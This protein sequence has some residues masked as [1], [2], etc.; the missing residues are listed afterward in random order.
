MGR[1][2]WKRISFGDPMCTSCGTAPMKADAPARIVIVSGNEAGRSR[3]ARLL[4]EAGYIAV[5]AGGEAAAWKLIATNPSS[6]GLVILD[7]EL[8]NQSGLALCRRIKAEYPDIPVLLTSAAK[9]SPKARG[10]GFKAGADAYL[11]EPAENVEILAHIRALYRLRNADEARRQGEKPLRETE[12][13]LSAPAGAA[14]G[15]VN[16][17]AG[18]AEDVTGRKQAEERWRESEE[19][20][21]VT[22]ET[23]AVGMTHAAPDGRWLRVN[24]AFSDIV[25]YSRQELLAG[26]TFADITH[27]DD[28]DADWR[29]F[30]EVLAGSRDSY[31]LEKRYIHK[32]GHFVHALIAVSAV[33]KADGAPDYLISAVQDISERKCAEAALRESEEKY[34][35][36]FESIDEGFCVIDIILDAAGRPV[37]YRFLEV[38]AVFEHQTGLLNAAGKTALELVPDLERWWIDTYGRVALTGESARFEHGSVPMGRIFDVYAS[39]VGGDTSRKVALVFKDITE[40][41]RIEERLRDSEAKFRTITNLIPGIVWTA[42]AVGAA[43]YASKQWYEF[44]GSAPDAPVGKMFLEVVHPD[45][46]QRSIAGWAKAQREGTVYQTE[47]RL[48]SRTGDYRWFFTRGTPIRDETGAIVQWFGVSIDVHD[49]RQT[50]EALRLSERQYRA[51]FDNAAIGIAHVGL[52]GRFLR[53]NARLCEKL[54]FGREELLTKTWMDLSHPDEI[55]YN[56]ELRQ[57]ALRGETQTY[58]LEKRLFRKDGAVIWAYL[59]AGLLRDDYGNPL[60]FIAFIQN[61]TAR[62]EA[63]ERLR[64]SEERFRTVAAVIP[65]MVWAAAPDGA[66]TYANDQWFRYCGL[67]PDQNARQWPELVLHP[68]DRARCLAAWRQ[69]LATGEDYEIE[70]R[71]RRYDGAYRWFLTR[72]RAL[73]NARGQITAW[74]GT[75]TDIHDRRAA[76]EQLRYQLQLVRSIADTAAVSIFVN[77]EAG[78]IVFINPEA[79]RVFGYAFD[80]LKGKSLHEI[81]HYKY[82]DG[83]PF[84]IA[85]CPLGFVY[86]DGR[87]VRDYEGVF[88]RKDGS[89]VNV[90][91]SNMPIHE[92]GQSVGDVITVQDIT[93]RK[94]HEERQ[95]MLMHELNHRVKNTLATVQSMAMQTLRNSPNLSEAKERF[96]ARLMA[97]SKAHDVLTRE[98]WEGAFLADIVERAVAPYCGEGRDRFVIEGPAIRVSPRR[99]LAL[100]MALHELCTNAVKYGALSNDEGKVTIAWSVSNREAAPKLEMRWSEKDGPPVVPPSRKGFGSRLIERGLASDL[101]GEVKIA[102]AETGLTC[103]IVAPLGRSEAMPRYG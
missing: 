99:A 64:D 74:F 68:D 96:E 82:P 7:R 87:P 100:A 4:R 59:T 88:W 34:R 3:K 102:F 19:R 70:V 16:Q 49:A 21:R 37:D 53:V 47:E 61:V 57:A 45:D 27:P 66:I 43:D 94:R 8:P 32:D 41:Q 39:R 60:Y 91:C 69:A 72:A 25:G 97:L 78:N 92:D 5:E 23:A 93:E 80:E 26:M 89:P 11:I 73:R 75:T 54:G 18:S 42:P 31:V 17:V 12:T 9:I 52:D 20:F 29:L 1:K 15:Q 35:N 103:V 36:L 22:F 24:N 28:R 71:N 63:E 40:R 56:L 46:R 67:T 38:N 13:R 86:E 62:K 6:I 33:R 79:E 90:V 83:R 30:R 76:E 51:T 10:A 48:R 85:E 65:S 95:K 44:T 58:S 50:Q 14:E 2:R 98:K 84:P 77:D 55:P 81:L 101:G